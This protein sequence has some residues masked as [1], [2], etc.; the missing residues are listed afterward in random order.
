M[1]DLANP[2]AARPLMPDAAAQ[3]MRPLAPRLSDADAESAKLFEK[4]LVD[5][6]ADRL[7][8]P[9]A[10][11]A[12][13]RRPDSDIHKSLDAFFQTFGDLAKFD[14]QSLGAIA[15]N[16]GRFL[17]NNAKEGVPK[18][19]SEDVFA[20]FIDLYGD[21]KR[22]RSAVANYDNVENLIAQKADFTALNFGVAQLR[23]QENPKTPV[24][25][26]A[27]YIEA[28]IHGPVLLAEDVEE[29]RIDV[30]EME[31][32]FGL[33][34][35]KLPAEEKEG[36]DRDEWVRSR[37]DEAKA[38][39]LSDT[40]NAPFKVAFYSSYETRERDDQVYFS[41]MREQESAAVGH[42]R[43]EFAAYGNLL[44]GERRGELMAAVAKKT[45]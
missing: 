11:L 29:I 8:D 19:D 34:F 24:A 15:L 20:H 27:S 38:E 17:A 12:E 41:V 1:A 5:A 3:A 2:G 25:S 13:L 26:S 21:K 32:H 6:F 39:I 43:D 31:E 30:D 7:K 40:R 4:G 22:A 37:C 10:A 44:L 16:I 45:A 36:F 33:V 42:L 18:P 23:E 9:Q 28:Q 14:A 35:N